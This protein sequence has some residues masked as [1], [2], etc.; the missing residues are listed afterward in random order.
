MASFVD[1]WFVH[2]LAMNGEP[3]HPKSSYMNKDR[4]GKLKAGPVWDFDW[5]TF[6]PRKAK[7]FTIKDAIY[8]ARLFSDPAF[9]AVVKER[10]AAQKP[11]F[12]GISDYIRSVAS[13]IEVSNEID[14]EIWPYPASQTVNG[15]EQMSFDDAVERIISAYE[16]KLAWLDTQINGM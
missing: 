11:M 9:V 3:N 8:Y 10:W 13:K 16:T 7:S 14:A 15:D 5:E 1:W 12:D 4:L 2:E 6:V